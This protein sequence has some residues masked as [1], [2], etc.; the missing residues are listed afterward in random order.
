MGVTMAEVAQRAG[1]S[2]ST[3]SHV[4]NATRPVSPDL[5]EAVRAAVSETGYVPNSLARALRTSRT[6]TVGLAMPAISNPYLGGLVRSLQAEAEEHGY[7]LLVSDTHDDPDCEDRAVRDLCERQVDGVLLAPSALPA[8]ALRHLADRA[9]PVALIDRL[10]PGPY[11]R[12]GVENVQSTAELV[13]H[14]VGHGHER[15]GLVSGLAGLVTT[16][17]RLEGYCLGL[18]RAGLPTDP[19][20]VVAGSS[21]DVHARLAVLELFGAPRPPTGLVVT[22]NHMMIGAVRA[23]R[24]LGLRVPGDVGLVGF[25]DFEWADLFS[26]RLTTMA[27]P[28]T[29]IGQDAVRLLLR[30]L[31]DREA[32]VRTLRL[33]PTLVVRNS[34]G[35][36]GS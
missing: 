25:D 4:L 35:C 29:Q 19:R 21:D 17:E 28:D 15:I 13:G 2:V 31:R 3:V 30:R 26:P 33:A 9:V 1:V 32:P 6:H 5:C 36:S 11:D 12:V 16:D 10:V 20:L 23:L 8:R 14:L 24:E 18:T 22:N 27:Q 7:R 34:C